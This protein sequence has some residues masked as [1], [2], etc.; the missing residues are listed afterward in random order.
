MMR[1]WTRL[2]ILTL[3]ASVLPTTIG[4]QS[5]P[6]LY[7]VS[8]LEA[9]PASQGQV[10]TM[11]RQLADASRKAGAVRYDVLQR[12]PESNQFVILEIWK[13]QQALDA[14]TN[15]AQTKQFR[16]Q[17]TPLLLAP[18]D[19]RLCI[20]TTVAPLRDARGGVV[21]VTHVDV[22]PPG[23]DA[24]AK[25]IQGF[26]DQSR[27]DPGN[28]RFDVTHEKA[29]SNHFTVIAV[30][31]DQKSADEHQTSAQT[32]AFRTQIAPFGGALYDE[33]WYKPL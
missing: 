3:G 12:T 32:K 24:A 6:T 28:V 9:L 2:L 5:D 10:A 29:K 19:S 17:V 15:A 27:K 13:D 22:A 31:A 20:A 26:A 7:V 8:Y 1:V 14:H 16:D 21:A 18:I 11:L 25:L 30:W 23:R 33:R 4:A